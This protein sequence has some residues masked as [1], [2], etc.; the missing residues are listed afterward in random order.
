MSAARGVTGEVVKALKAMGIRDKLKIMTGGQS[1]Y[2]NDIPT[3]GVDAH[4]A[5]I[6]E[7]LLKSAELMRILR[8]RKIGGEK[9]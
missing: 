3:Y 5:D 8:E 1:S 2:E 9:Q 7:A 4:G 6:D